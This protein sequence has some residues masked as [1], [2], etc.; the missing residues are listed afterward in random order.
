MKIT[1]TIFSYNGED[2]IYITKQVED[3]AI[4]IQK[5][6][7]ILATQPAN[8]KKEM[9]EEP[10]NVLYSTFDLGVQATRLLTF[11]G[12]LEAFCLQLEA[13]TAS[14]LE[15]IEK[16]TFKTLTNKKLLAQTQDTLNT[17]MMV[18]TMFVKQISQ[19]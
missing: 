16:N 7:D 13:V 12:T 19:N 18:M 10:S 17:L 4:A 8:I 3:A 15:R 1:D 9:D 6:R 5:A 2:Q 14:F 11:E